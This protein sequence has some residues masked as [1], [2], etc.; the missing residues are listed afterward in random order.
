MCQYNLSY[1]N[2]EDPKS[3][4]P[5]LKLVHSQTIRELAS[6]TF[7]SW[8]LAMSFAQPGYRDIIDDDPFPWY[9]FPDYCEKEKLLTHLTITGEEPNIALDMDRQSGQRTFRGEYGTKFEP[10]GLEGTVKSNFLHA[11]HPPPG[12]SFPTMLP[13]CFSTPMMFSRSTASAMK[14]M[15]EYVTQSEEYVFDDNIVDPRICK[16]GSATNDRR[17][18]F[19]TGSP[20]LTAFVHESGMPIETG[21]CMVEANVE[22]E[23]SAMYSLIKDLE[24]LELEDVQPVTS[25]PL[26]VSSE[27]WIPRRR[28]SQIQVSSNENSVLSNASNTPER[29]VSNKTSNTSLK[30]EPH[31]SRT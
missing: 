14:S 11:K 22:G 5:K 17:E 15:P 20:L 21:L 30:S 27:D 18:L 31:D 28:S 6:W 16:P 7:V 19:S 25:V 26:I 23:D 29:L 13:P 1:A 4:Y 3:G 24:V 2:I 10:P 9:R 12:L 8:P